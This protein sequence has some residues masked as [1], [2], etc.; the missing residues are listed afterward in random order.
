MSRRKKLLGN[1]LNQIKA[2]IRP[3]S[4]SNEL[5]LWVTVLDAKP[6]DLSSTPRTHMVKER[7]DSHKLSSDS[8]HPSWHVHTDT[9][10]QRHTQKH[11]LNK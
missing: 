5:A 11:T 7:T 8:I 9:D 3:K 4:G 2:S 1:L 10:T 6:E